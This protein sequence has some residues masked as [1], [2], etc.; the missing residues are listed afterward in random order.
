MPAGITVMAG[1]ATIQLGLGVPTE[2]S[3]LKA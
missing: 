3:R 1:I 2:K